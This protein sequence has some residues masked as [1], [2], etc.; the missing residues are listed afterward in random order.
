MHI[1]LVET[2]CVTW[3]LK[4][5]SDCLS[6]LNNTIDKIFLPDF[7]SSCFMLLGSSIKTN[8]HEFTISVL[9]GEHV[10]S[11]MFW[12]MNKKPFESYLEMLKS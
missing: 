8:P 12:K 11:H 10:G 7:K 1:T 6:I 5:D 2:L 9:P 3:I 4:I